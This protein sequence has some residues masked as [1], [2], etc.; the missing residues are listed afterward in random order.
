MQFLVLS[1]I[2][3]RAKPSPM[4]ACWNGGQVTMGPAGRDRR[5]RSVP[6]RRQPGARD[7][8]SPAEAAPSNAPAPRKRPANRLQEHFTG[9]IFNILFSNTQTPDKRVQK[10]KEV[11]KQLCLHQLCGRGI[12]WTPSWQVPL[13]R[14]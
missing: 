2:M 4:S 5:V 1:W 7:E 9:K 11:A 6:K 14:P 3:A 12:L 8:D 13:F 10:E